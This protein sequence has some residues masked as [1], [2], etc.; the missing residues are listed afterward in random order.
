MKPSTVLMFP[1]QS[2]RDPA[3]IERIIRDQPLLQ[4]VLA[5]AAAVLGRNLARHYRSD[6]PVIFATNRDIQVGV[7]L[8]NHLHMEALLANS[9][10]A[11]GSLGLSLG[12][13]NHLVHIGALA[14]EDALRLVDRRGALYDTGPQGCMVSVFP[15]DTATIKAAIAAAGEADT[16]AVALDNSPKQKVI[17]GPRASVQRVLASLDDAGFFQSVEIEGRIPMH[18]PVF[19]PVAAGFRKV[20][21]DTPFRVAR[22]PYLPNVTACYV[23]FPS[24]DDF[25]DALA[26]HVCER[27][28]WRASVEAAALRHPDATFIECGPKAVLSGLFGRGWTPVPARRTDHG[29]H[30]EFGAEEKEPDHAG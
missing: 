21:A 20:L 19:A 26:R 23:D 30:F 14:F 13:F 8:A 10:E 3:M 24:R 25:A 17:A 2:S 12:E 16:V 27:V 29:S 18:V 22:M 15:V 7:F 11:A 1:G 5:G 28:Q 4:G 9:G 6:N